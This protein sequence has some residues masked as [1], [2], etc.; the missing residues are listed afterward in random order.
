[1]NQF[2]ESQYTYIKTWN[3]TA[4][5]GQRCRVVNSFN[6]PTSPEQRWIINYLAPWLDKKHPKPAMSGEV[7]YYIKRDE[8]DGPEPVEIKGKLVYPMSR[9]FILSKTSDN[10]LL[11]ATGY[12]RLLANLPPELA[13]LTDFAS[14]MQ[15][16]PYQVI[17]TKWVELAQDRWRSRWGAGYDPTRTNETMPTIRNTLQ[18]AIAGDIARGGTDETVIATRHADNVFLWGYAGKETPDGATAASKLLQHRQGNSRMS[19]DV[20]GWGSSA[21]DHLKGLGH[22]PYAFNGSTASPARTRSG[23]FGFVNK[24]AEAYWKLREMLDP[25]Y[26]ATLSLPPHPKLLGDL[27]APRWFLSLRGIQVEEKAEIKK[28]LGRS[29]DTGDAVVMV[30]DVGGLV[31][32]S[33]F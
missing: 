18:D 26:G 16:D 31:Y 2:L 8:V 12:D 33:S 13:A 9:C 15:D 3:R 30:C 29:P 4:E 24:R 28:R 23:Q 14:S 25:E 32:G 21:Y 10:A 27:T 5:P 6:P 22:Q 11:M 20:I 19:I 17:P 7:R 1:M